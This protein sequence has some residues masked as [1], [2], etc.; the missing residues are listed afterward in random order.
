MAIYLRFIWFWAKVI[1]S[2]WNNFYAVWQI[3]IAENGQILKKQ[4]GRLVTLANWCRKL[5]FLLLFE[6]LIL[7]FYSGRL[8]DGLNEV[9]DL[10]LPLGRL[11]QVLL[12]GPQ[13]TQDL[14]QSCRHR[15]QLILEHNLLWSNDM[16]LFDRR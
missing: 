6:R 1:S 16:D 8:C 12:E 2:L 13:T 5:L 11:L 15:R 4:S 9:A 14:L 10:L 3:L 7:R